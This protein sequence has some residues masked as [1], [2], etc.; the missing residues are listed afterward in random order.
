MRFL[1]LLYRLYRASNWIENQ[2]CTFW[3]RLRLFENYSIVLSYVEASTHAKKNRS[4]NHDKKSFEKYANAG[5]TSAF[6]LFG[7]L[8]LLQ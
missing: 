2:F 8:I 5:F 1:T 4:A 6:S 3:T 7:T